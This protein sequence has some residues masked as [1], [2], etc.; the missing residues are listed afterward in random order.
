MVRSCL[1]FLLLAASFSDCKNKKS[2][3]TESDPIV[4]ITA[5]G[6]KYHSKDCSSLKNS[7]TSIAL[8]EAVAQ[9]YTAC[10]RCKP[11]GK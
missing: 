3:A 5:T 9:G 10:G 4:Y 7:K 6:K 1:F 11:E 8:A 2:G